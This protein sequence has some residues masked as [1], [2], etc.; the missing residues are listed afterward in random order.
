MYDLFQAFRK[1]SSLAKDMSIAI[2]KLREAGE[3]AKMEQAWF[4]GKSSFVSDDSV[5]NP[6]AIDLETF[7]GLFIVT[8]ITSVMALVLFFAFYIKQKYHSLITK[9]DRSEFVRKL[10]MS[11]ML[12]YLNRAN[13]RE[14]NTI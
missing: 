5:K 14:T 12:E 6:S 9:S 10:H 2:A 11:R 1:G 8:G 3:L 13:S 7:R 4:H